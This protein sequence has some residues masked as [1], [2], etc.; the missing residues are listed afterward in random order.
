MQVGYKLNEENIPVC[1]N[2]GAKVGKDRKPQI[3]FCANCGTPMN[4][5]SAIKLEETMT[6]EKLN[7]IYEA[8][9]EIENGKDAKTVLKTFIKELSE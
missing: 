9:E 3:N 4:M 7:V 8:L 1:M 6:Q 2:C 5:Q